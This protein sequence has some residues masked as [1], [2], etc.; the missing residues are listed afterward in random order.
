MLYGINTRSFIFFL[1]LSVSLLLPLTIFGQD[2]HFLISSYL[3]R[4]DE[5][6]RK[7]DN[8][9]ISMKPV[10]PSI[11]SLTDPITAN[12]LGAKFY[13]DG[14]LEKATAAFKHAIDLDADM[15]SA[16]VNL[17]RTYQKL[18][19]FDDALVSA[20][21]GADLHPGNVRL[22]ANYCRAAA[23]TAGDEALKCFSDLNKLTPNDTEMLDD[24]GSLLLIKLKDLDKALSVF[25]SVVR[26]APTDSSAFNAVGYIYFQK[27]RYKESAE[28]FKARVE[29]DPANSMYRL[30][31]AIVSCKRNDRP[32]ALSQYRLLKESNPE[33][34]QKLYDLL[35][36][37]WIVKA[38]RD[39]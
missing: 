32:A 29:I 4:P 31:L 30:N 34:A 14:Q 19:R 5:A 6:P 23:D 2:S 17:T 20:R 39:Q 28:A 15:A 18:K 12:N 9:T 16:Y 33:M 1:F 37:G 36:Q 26:L 10:E 22:L 35:Y 3:Q 38:P 27:K 7:S 25:Q 8:K 24:Y 11:G 21:R 13:H